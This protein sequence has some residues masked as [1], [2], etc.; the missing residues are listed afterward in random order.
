MFLW[1]PT[2]I[3]KKRIYVHHTFYTLH[4]TYLYG[5][6]KKTCFRTSL[7]PILFCFFVAENS[8]L[9]IH[10]LHVSQD[11]QSVKLD[12]SH[13]QSPVG[14]GRSKAPSASEFF[15]P[16]SLPWRRYY[17]QDYGCTNTAG[18]MTSVNSPNFSFLQSYNPRH[19]HH[20]NPPTNTAA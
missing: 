11:E 6:A 5:S 9:S 20:F 13:L 8:G 14:V 17:M 7:K 19:L 1:L 16:S 10:I 2:K 3:F 12:K 18:V 15:F 4:V